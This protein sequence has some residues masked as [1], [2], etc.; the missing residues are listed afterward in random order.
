MKLQQSLSTQSNQGK[1]FR[2]IQGRKLLITVIALFVWLIVYVQFVKSHEYRSTR[3]IMQSAGCHYVELHNIPT[4]AYSVPDTCSVTASYRP[5]VFG[6]GGV[7]LQGETYIELADNQ[8]MVAEV[9][10]EQPWTEPQ[11]SAAKWFGLASLVLIGL[12]AVL[13]L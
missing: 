5:D 8:I 11:I 12:I 1:Q 4:H 13:F 2:N 9:L 10:Q 6:Q 7:V 3:L